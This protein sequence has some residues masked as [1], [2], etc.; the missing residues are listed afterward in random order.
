MG[1]RADRA[2]THRS[3]AVSF[4]S[5]AK[6]LGVNRST[7]TRWFQ[8][9]LRG[10]RLRAGVADAGHPDFKAF[11]RQK[12]FDPRSAFGSVER[13]VLVQQQM[14]VPAGD[15]VARTL[16]IVTAEQLAELSGAGLDDVLDQIRGPLAGAVVPIGHLSAEQFA[17]YAELTVDQVIA[18]AGAELAG[19]VTKDRL[20]DLG[21][22]TALA[23]MAAHPF[24]RDNEDVP[25]VPQ[26]AGDDFLAPAFIGED[27]DS[28]HPVALV[29]L[30]RCTG[31]VPTDADFE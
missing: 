25:V 10:A 2:P 1:K 20:L 18:A 5:L 17:A 3:L 27:I 31:R 4:V 8:G 9:P 16:R 14:G 30:A 7:I 11:L 12:G 23:F 29:Y 6:R 26:I 15:P 21:S 24:A 28:A 13:L 19:A 22:A